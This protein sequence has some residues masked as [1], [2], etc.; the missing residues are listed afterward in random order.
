M[1]KI[2]LWSFMAITVLMTSSCNLFSSDKD[3]GERILPSSSGSINEMIVVIKHDLWKGEVGTVVRDIFA[4]D[5]DGLPQPEPLY[6]IAQVDPVNFGSV[7]KNAR[8][9]LIVELKQGDK[10]SLNIQ[11]KVYAQ[12]QVVETLTANTEETLI[13]ALRKYKDDLVKEFHDQDIKSVQARY[14]RISNYDIPFIEEKGISLILP[15]SYEKVQVNEDFWWYRSNIREGRLYPS[16]NFLLYITPLKSDL[17]LSGQSIISIRDSI[18]KK[19]VGGSVDRSYMQTELRPTYAPTMKNVLIDGKVA[20]ETRGLWMVKGDFM[21]GPFV[22]YTIFDEENK[23]IITAD[24][25]VY[26]AGTKKRN[27]VFEMEAIIKSMKIK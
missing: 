2:V 22:S 24:G 21:G 7:F 17:D 11:K 19:Y 15:I 1:Q 12:P 20:I 4:Q 16:L 25:F 23:R 10:A 18:A 3:G 14:K 27:Y 26:A 9:I 13:K 8:N 5:I 6:R